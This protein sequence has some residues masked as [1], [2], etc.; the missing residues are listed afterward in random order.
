MA[1]RARRRPS[2]TSAGAFRRAEQLH[3]AV[4]L[5]AAQSGDVPGDVVVGEHPHHRGADAVMRRQ[6]RGGRAPQVL[7]PPGGADEVEVERGVQLVGAQV[8]RE[9]LGAGDPRLADEDLR[10]VVGVR[11]IAPLPVDVVDLRP[12]PVRVVGAVRRRQDVLGVVA[13]VG[14]VPLLDQ[15]VGDVDAEAVGAPV[16]PEPQDVQE[17]L[18]D[19]RVVPVEVGLLGVEQVQVPLARCAV[20]LGHPL[21]GRT[22]ED[23]QPI[24]RGLLAVVTSPRAEEVSVPLRRAGARRQG[25]LEP[26][27]LVGRVVGD[28]VEQDPQPQLMRLADERDGLVEGPERRVDVAIVGDVVPA[29]RLR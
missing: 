26:R 24:V 9:A 16:E 29:V 23:R 18:T 20:G 8:R 21:P 22:A 1:A 6:A 27:V 14:Q 4:R 5:F 11:Q 15:A 10:R 19:V 7:G 28:D 13:D 17:L 12:V 3:R 2:S 25:G